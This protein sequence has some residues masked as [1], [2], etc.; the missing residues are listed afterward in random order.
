MQTKTDAAPG[1]P[2]MEAPTPHERPLNG[3]VAP[4]RLR[5]GRHG[6][7][8]DQVVDIQRQRILRAMAEV[9]S[10][11]GFAA[12]TVESVIARAKVSR[13]TFYQLFADRH[14]CFLAVFDETVKRV[15]VG[16]CAAYRAPGPWVE[17]VRDGLLELLLFLDR[18]PLLAKICVV[19]SMAGDTAMLAHRGKVIRALTQVADEGRCLVRRREPPSP[20]TA[21]GIVGGVFSIVH[22]RLHEGECGPLRDLLGPLMAVIVLPYLGPAA[23][24]RELARPAPEIVSD[25]VRSPDPNGHMSDLLGELGTRMT[26]RTVRVLEVI[27]DQPGLS[28][29]EAARAAG[30]TDQGQISRLLARLRS[31]GLVANHRPGNRRGLSNAWRLTLKGEE[32]QRAIGVAAPDHADRRATR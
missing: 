12:A 21:E 17:R 11:R 9:T 16:V 15:A 24:Y 20:L 31:A 5:P 2:V 25:P 6:L 13:R 4:S 10:E 32:I 3:R 7:P 14:D 19:G 22:A 28:N 8:S 30:V 26:Y 27:G 29:R 23:A 18:E 1:G